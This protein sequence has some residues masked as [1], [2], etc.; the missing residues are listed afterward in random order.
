MA[1]F[2]QLFEKVAT[3]RQLFEK[4][5]NFSATFKHFYRQL[6]DKLSATCAKPYS[7]RAAWL[8]LS[9]RKW[10]F[11]VHNGEGLGPGVI[12]WRHCNG[13]HFVSHMAYV[14]DAKFE[15]HH[16]NISRDILDFVIYFCTEMI[17]DVINF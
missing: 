12:S 8:S 3:F 16:S 2:R 5:S 1:T 7:S 6:L 15:Q 14:I 11:L 9:G 17:C 4:S 13:R 10:R